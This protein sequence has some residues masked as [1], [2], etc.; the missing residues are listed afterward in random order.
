[1]TG[2]PTSRL[3]SV[4]VGAENDMA[5]TLKITKAAIKGKKEAPSVFC[6]PDVNNIY[7]WRLLEIPICGIP[8]R[9]EPRSV[10]GR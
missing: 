4:G 3:G 8:H 9:T 7:R 2:S 10:A 6:E 5:E 1:M